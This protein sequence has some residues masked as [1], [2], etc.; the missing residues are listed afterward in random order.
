M[1]AA[2][3]LVG[4]NR[5][6]LVHMFEYVGDWFALA[7]YLSTSRA[8]LTRQAALLHDIRGDALLWREHVVYQ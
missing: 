5:E 4:E 8:W 1:C 6:I 7:V 3:E 2:H